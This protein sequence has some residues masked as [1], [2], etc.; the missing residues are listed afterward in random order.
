[1]SKLNKMNKVSEGFTLLE[2][3][4]ALALSAILA[5][6]VFAAFNYAERSSSAGLKRSDE[7]E[8]LR[9]AQGFLREHIEGL[10]PLR[11]TK[12]LG[13]PIRFKG[14]RERLVYVSPVISRIAEGGTLWWSLSVK[15]QENNQLALVLERLPMDMLELSF[16]DFSE[17]EK[18]VLAENVKGVRFS[19][20]DQED[21]KLTGIWVDD[22]PHEQRLPKLIRIEV[23]AGHSMR[24]PELVI[25]PQISLELGCPNW[26]ENTRRCVVPGATVAR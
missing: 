3:M 12:Q 23:D 14:E 25:A 4:V 6:L 20:Y 9:R 21:P 22:W 2:V 11:F 19:Y 13:Q 26:Q 1:M 15:R 7:M 16:P 5:T 17:K 8:D 18:N 10:L 24:W